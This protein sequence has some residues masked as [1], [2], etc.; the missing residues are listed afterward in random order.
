MVFHQPGKRGLAL[1]CALLL[2]AGPVAAKGQAKDRPAG[3]GLS[4]VEGRVRAPDGK[5]GVAGAKIHAYN[6]ATGQT[7]SSEPTGPNGA[8]RIEGLPFGYFELAVETGDGLFV[9]DQ[10]VNVG[11]SAKALVLLTLKPYDQQPDSWW[12]DHERR[13]FSGSED[14]SSGLAELRRRRTGREFVRSTKGVVLLST[15]GAAV[16][17][18]IAASDDE[19][20]ASPIGGGF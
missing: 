14:E 20:S 17:L 1:I 6:Q 18:V 11:P 9:A 7:Y 3:D 12:A 15:V 13:S 10:I 5:R 19:T 4:S 2:L 16:L 8:Y